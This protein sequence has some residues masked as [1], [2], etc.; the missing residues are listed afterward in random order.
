[1]VE[2]LPVVDFFVEQIMLKYHNLFFEV[3][4]WNIMKRILL[5][6]SYFPIAVWASVCE[7]P[8]DQIVIADVGLGHDVRKL[9]KYK[10]EIDNKVWN[11]NNS[12]SKFG[13]ALI[14]PKVEKY[15][16]LGTPVQSFSYIQYY[17]RNYLISGYSVS[18]NLDDINH[19]KL[20]KI[21]TELYG[22]PKSNWKIKK[23][24]DGKYGEFVD[25]KY[26]CD[27]YTILINS[28][29]AAGSFMVIDEK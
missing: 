18:F 22:L 24:V 6:A 7:V 2:I 5:I 17:K 8:K 26:E 14:G 11:K 15:W 20:R 23:G 10:V 28:G 16:L 21:L 12:N 25:Q 4:Y 27:N 19:I 1:M 29:S 3:N 9:E 13:E